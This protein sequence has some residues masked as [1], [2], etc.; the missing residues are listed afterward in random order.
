MNNETLCFHSN[1][2]KD[3][4]NDMEIILKSLYSAGLRERIISVFHEGKPE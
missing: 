3:I 1:F 4:Y 2:P